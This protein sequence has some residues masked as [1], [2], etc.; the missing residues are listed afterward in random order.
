MSWFQNLKIFPKLLIALSLVLGI[1]TGIGVFAV[2]QLADLH[3]AMRNIV[4]DEMESV[5]QVSSIVSDFRAYRVAELQHVLASDP[6]PM[7]RYERI[8]DELSKQMTNAAMAYEPLIVDNEERRIYAELG[9]LW[10][11]YQAEHEKLLAVSRRNEDEQARVIINGQS[12]KIFEEMASK[13]LGLVGINLR[14]SRDAATVA[15]HTYEDARQLITVLLVAGFLM[16]FFL[17]TLISLSISRP[18]S[19]AAQVAGRIAEGDLSVRLDEDRQDETGMLL[20]AMRSMVQ[21]LAQ[22]IGEVRAGAVALTSAAAQ[23]SSSSQSLSQGTAEQASSVEETTAS[24]E[25]MNATIEQN[26]QHS[27]LME[28]IAVKGAQEASESGEAVK[29]TVD[30]MGAIAK[31][32][33]IIEEIAYQTNLLALNAAIEAARAGEH[34]KGFAVVATEVRKLAERSRAAAQEISELAGK[35]VKVSERSGELLQALVPSIQKT[36]QLVQ[37]V[38]A[39]SGE[40]AVGVRQVNRAMMQVDQVTQRNASAA[41]E[42]SATAEEMSAQADTLQQLVSFFRVGESESRTPWPT[43]HKPGGGKPAQAGK[44]PPAW[45][46]SDAVH[47]LKAISHGSLS[48]PPSKEEKRLSA[49]SSEDREF[50]RF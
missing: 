8:M 31:K 40:Q 11:E 12:A 32:I 15:D 29:Q 45:S 20:A 9:A 6:E 7:A 26:S 27:R 5:F 25:E 3:R 41:E 33:N 21:R 23:V 49:L 48:H 18:L 24:L 4:D 13:Q 34:G 43:L 39:A 36:A 22:V 14:T 30:A 42:L 47:G 10:R 19:H 46:D 50:K 37:E 1:A 44:A 17:C 38:V 28:Q 16:G 35:S 2:R